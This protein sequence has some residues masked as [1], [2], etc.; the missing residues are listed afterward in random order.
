MVFKKFQYVDHHLSSF[1]GKWNG[2]GNLFPPLSCYAEEILGGL[3]PI[4]LV[5]KS[6]YVRASF[7][8]LL[9]LEV[10]KELAWRLIG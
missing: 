4:S 1:D 5:S 9:Y 7:P 8:V 2:N 10:S 6:G 3:R